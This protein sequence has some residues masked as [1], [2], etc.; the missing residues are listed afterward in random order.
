MRQ[1]SNRME[2]T[3]YHEKNV[4]AAKWNKRSYLGERKNAGELQKIQLSVC[5]LL[6]YFDY[7]CK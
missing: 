4:I 3:C 5:F 6:E 1:Y 7:S 2:K